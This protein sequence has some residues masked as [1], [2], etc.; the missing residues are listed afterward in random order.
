MFPTSA[1]AAAAAAATMNPAAA[2][3]PV[4]GSF[5]VFFTLLALFF[6]FVTYV[7]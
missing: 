3:H 2:R 6:L 7:G 5:L 4:S 1:A